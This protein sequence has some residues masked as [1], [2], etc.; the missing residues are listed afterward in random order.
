MTHPRQ[1]SSVQSVASTRS[2]KNAHMAS[3]L[4]RSLGL[5]VLSLGALCAAGASAQAFPNKPLRLVVTFPP[6]GAPDILA[7][8]FSEKAQLRFFAEQAGQDVGRSARREGHH[9]A[10]GFVGK[11]LR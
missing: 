7:R 3:P 11:G 8:L 6:G 4:R 1:S 5:L 10:Q 9:Q 2:T